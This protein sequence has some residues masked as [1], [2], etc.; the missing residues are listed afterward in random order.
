MQGKRHGHGS[1]M[2]FQGEKLVQR[3]TGLKSMM[4]FF[5]SFF[6]FGKKGLWMTLWQGRI[7]KNILWLP[8]LRVVHISKL[9]YNRTEIIIEL[10]RDQSLSAMWVFSI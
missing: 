1:H 5:L 6:G 7:T 9:D 8:I 4:N 2:N 10:K 3:Y